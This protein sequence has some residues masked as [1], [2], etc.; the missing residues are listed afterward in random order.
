MRIGCGLAEII[1]WACVCLFVWGKEGRRSR[2]PVPHLCGPE[3]EERGS[4]PRFRVRSLLVQEAMVAPLPQAPVRPP[5]RPCVWPRWGQKL[6][7]SLP[8]EVRRP[9]FLWQRD[10]IGLFTRPCAQSQSQIVSQRSLLFTSP[11]CAA[12]QF[13]EKAVKLAEVSVG[14]ASLFLPPKQREISRPGRRSDV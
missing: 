2:K 7:Q 4:S 1:A 11:E 8:G 6:P 9:H 10:K 5:V 3:L 14:S 13:G 12:G